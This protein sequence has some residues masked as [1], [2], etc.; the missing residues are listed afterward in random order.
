[1]ANE[2][3]NAS[4]IEGVAGAGNNAALREK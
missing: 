4:L 2:I 1:L 3:K